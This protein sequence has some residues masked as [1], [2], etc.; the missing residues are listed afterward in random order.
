M[1][2]KLY[3]YKLLALPVVRQP[4]SIYMIESGHDTYSLYV[5]DRDGNLKDQ[6]TKVVPIT[7]NELSQ[8]AITNSLRT[9]DLWYVSDEGRLAIPNS[10]STFQV[11]FAAHVGPTP[12]DDTTVIWFDTGV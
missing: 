3:F 1:T 7:R 2:S 5:T 8:L 4:D 10:E 12:P 6:R 9:G 11:F